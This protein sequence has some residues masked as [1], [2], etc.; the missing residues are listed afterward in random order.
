MRVG[1]KWEQAV[2]E[3]QR[4]GNAVPANTSAQSTTPARQT[5][6]P[7]QTGPAPASD[8]GQR[9]A[10][11]HRQSGRNRQT[12]DQARTSQERVGR[13]QEERAQVRAERQQLRDARRAER[14]AERQ[15][16]QAERRA[17]GGAGQVDAT[18]QPPSTQG[19]TQTPAD[20]ATAPAGG[21]GST[22]G[23]PAP[24]TEAPQAPPPETTVTETQAQTAE[25]SSAQAPP[26]ETTP[27]TA[28]PDAQTTVTQTTVTQ[29]TVTQTTVTQTTAGTSGTGS[30]IVISG[31]VRETRGEAAEDRVAVEDSDVASERGVTGVQ[32]DDPGE[33]VTFRFE[34]LG[35][36]QV[37][38]TRFETQDGQEVATGSQTLSIS[39]AGD[40]SGRGEAPGT[41]SF[42]NI[43]LELELDSSY[44]PGDLQFVEIA[45]GPSESG[46]VAAGSL[47]VQT[48]TANEPTTAEA[49][50]ARAPEQLSAR[51]REI[52]DA[53]SA[54]ESSLLDLVERL[55]QDADGSSG[56]VLSF[57][58]T[59]SRDATL[60]I[61][62]ETLLAQG[63]P[64]GDRVL[65]LLV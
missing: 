53:L 18:P 41:L 45:S 59:D 31:N 35:N 19:Q 42:D 22:G 21:A 5:Q 23:T 25:A 27:A 11:A 3:I 58:D 10:D 26:P 47:A 38:A 13:L 49:Q 28:T 30:G 7:D 50:R 34:D 16:A 60:R 51:E 15:Q 54:E 20:T 1:T 48:E 55:A 56:S 57:S 32:I 61:M 8:S 2:S 43:G 4:T 39:G 24:G 44:T 64:P 63:S 6:S 12:A 14:Q 36:G 46:Q 37:R 40:I 9:T 62:A 29:T 17:E 65:Q 52:D 33:G